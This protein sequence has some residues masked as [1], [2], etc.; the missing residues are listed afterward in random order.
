M[1]LIRIDALE[2]RGEPE[3]QSLLD[4][5]HRAMLS[6]FPVPVRDRYQIY[7][8]HPASHVVAQD[9]GLGI[10]RT[11]NLVIV[12]VVSRERSQEMKE[13]FYKELCRELKENCAI[14]S[15]DVIVSIVT[16]SSADWSFGK[17]SAQFLTGEL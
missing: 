11:K 9:T 15:S 10:V 17:G 8:E 1:P 5:A 13:K 4:A 16:N 14:D 7:Q 3:I 2:G 12:S 6:A